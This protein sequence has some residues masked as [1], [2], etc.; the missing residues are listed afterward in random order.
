M[1][2]W[3]QGGAEEEASHKI[4]WSGGDMALCRLR[5]RGAAAARLLCCAVHQQL[6][7]KGSVERL[8]LFKD[9]PP[10]VIVRQ[11]LLRVHILTLLHASVV[12]VFT[13]YLARAL[14]DQ[15]IDP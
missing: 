12:I 5:T 13:L 11:P 6:P 14:P 1:A 3:P 8:L 15:N 10:Q 4:A 2:N 9:C 7:Q